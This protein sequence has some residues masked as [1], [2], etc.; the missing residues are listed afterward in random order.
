MSYFKLITFFEN[1]NKKLYKQDKEILF[2][3]EKNIS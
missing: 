2:N 1:I 3:N